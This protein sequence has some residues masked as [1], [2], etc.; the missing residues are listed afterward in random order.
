MDGVIADFDRSYFS[1]FG[2][3]CRDDPE[4]DNWVKFIR[5]HNGFSNLFMMDDAQELLDF[6]A[7]SNKKII[8]LS[9]AGSSDTFAEV[10]EQKTQWLHKHNLQQYPRIF[11]HTKKEKS[12][13]ADSTSILIDDSIQCIEPFKEAGGHV[14]LHKSALDTIKKLDNMQKVGIF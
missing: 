1:L 10:A 11:T 4:R 8:I 7:N 9:C 5:Q 13:M 6:L 2:L 14:V 3:N 12:L